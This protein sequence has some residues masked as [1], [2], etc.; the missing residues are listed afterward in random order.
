MALREKYQETSVMTEK[1][2]VTNLNDF[3]AQYNIEKIKIS[4]SATVQN[5]DDLP[6]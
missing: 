5:N 1:E 4:I 6:F 3:F 2:V